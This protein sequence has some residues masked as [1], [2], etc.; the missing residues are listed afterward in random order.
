M[1]L[2]SCIGSIPLKTNENPRKSMLFVEFS[3]F[4]R[5]FDNITLKQ[6][7]IQDHLNRLDFC[8]QLEKRI[9]CRT[10]EA[11]FH[12]FH[13]CIF[14]ADIGVL[15]AYETFLGIRPRKMLLAPHQYLIKNPKNE[16]N[17]ISLR[18]FCKEYVF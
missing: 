8:F 13:F 18:Q 5:K 16:G 15:T 14:L 11:K 6:T 2:E 1:S 17:G 10:V 12:F 7:C 4:S 9:P 3:M